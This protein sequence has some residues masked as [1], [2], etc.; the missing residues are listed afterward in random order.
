[1]FTRTFLSVSIASV[2]LSASLAVS[3]NTQKDKEEDSVKSWGQWSKQFATAAGGEINVAALVFAGFE[4][5]ETGRNAQNEA[6]YEDSGYTVDVDNAGERQ[7]VSWGKGYWGAVSKGIKRAEISYEVD[8]VE[9]WYEVTSDD[10]SYS[11]LTLAN[12][13]GISVN[14][15]SYQQSYFQSWDFLSFEDGEGDYQR[16]YW[17]EEGPHNGLGWPS[18]DGFFISGVTSSA[19]I[20]ENLANDVLAGNVSAIYNGAFLGNRGDVTIEV[21]FGK[22]AGWTGSFNPVDFVAFDAEGTFEG[23][24]LV[25][26]INTAGVSGTVGASFFGSNANVIAGIAEANAGEMGDFVGVFETT[27]LP[28][29][30]IVEPPVPVLPD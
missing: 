27:N 28:V 6:V 22:N 1:M 15:V 7:Y 4:Q 30:D 9:G 17:Y 19:Q 14:G 18:N 3:A 2:L 24:D 26:E 10:E 13:R 12:D 21:D 25:G 23:V 29:D 16:G 5:G 11:S 20:V 8:G